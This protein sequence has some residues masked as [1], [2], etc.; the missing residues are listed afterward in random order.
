M[1]KNTVATLK[2]RLP[3]PY[4]LE[5]R[6]TF[7]RRFL[8]NSVVKAMYKAVGPAQA[9]ATRAWEKARLESQVSITTPEG[10]FLLY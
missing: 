2:S 5:S 9:A 10:S 6:A 8:A 7:T 4:E 3:R 1:S